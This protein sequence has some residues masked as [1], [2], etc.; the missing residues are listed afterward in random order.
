MGHAA[1]V[2][3]LPELAEHVSKLGP[4]MRLSP[5]TTDTDGFYVAMMLR[6]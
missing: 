6:G 5:A 3:G 1:K 2:A 4:G